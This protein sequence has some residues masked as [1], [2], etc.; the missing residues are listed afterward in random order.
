MN[1]ISTVSF[2]VEELFKSNP[3]VNTTSFI[4]TEEM[5]SNKE[6]IYPLVNIN[7]LNQIVEDQLIYINYD[8]SV[9]EQRDIT[10]VLNND[11]M[12]GSNLIDNLNECSFIATK[13]INALRRLDNEDN[14]NI[15]TISDI[16][17][18]KNERGNGLD[19]VQFTISLSI[20]N[21]ISGC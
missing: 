6:N 1:T 14:I 9:V 18:L 7:I 20:Y 3:L 5:D 10:P 15:E 16:T 4:T 21:D 8:I 17:F 12:F 2:F 11:K 19:G 13:F